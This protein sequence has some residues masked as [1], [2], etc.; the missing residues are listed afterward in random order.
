M[1]EGGQGLG[2]QGLG[3]L[4]ECREEEEGRRGCFE[5][6]GEIKTKVGKSAESWLGLGLAN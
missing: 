5:R 3:I 6:E 1:T 2:G 4:V